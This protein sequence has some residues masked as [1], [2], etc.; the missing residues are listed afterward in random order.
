MISGMSAGKRLGLVTRVG[1]IWPCPFYLSICTRGCEGFPM[2]RTEE[3][4]TMI[5]TARI[6]ATTIV[7]LQ[8]IGLGGR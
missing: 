2:T 7:E 4:P 5:L 6:I 1:T 3:A 8:Q